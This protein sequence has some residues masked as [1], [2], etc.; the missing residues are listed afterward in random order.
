MITF[1]SCKLS[2]LFT[3]QCLP[4]IWSHLFEGRT[5][6]EYQTETY[7]LNKSWSYDTGCKWLK[8]ECCTMAVRIQ[9]YCAEIKNVVVVVVLIFLKYDGLSGKLADSNYFYTEESIRCTNKL[10]PCTH[11]VKVWLD[12]IIDLCYLIYHH[13]RRILITFGWDHCKILLKTLKEDIK[14]ICITPTWSV[15]I[16]SWFQ[17]HWCDKFVLTCIIKVYCRFQIIVL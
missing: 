7:L 13:A 1:H 15:L 2:D 3:E 16:F 11:F 14:R 8:I 17:L 4:N 9:D 12:S 5:V 10:Q 6:F